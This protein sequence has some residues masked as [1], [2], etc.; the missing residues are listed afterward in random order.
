MNKL[1]PLGRKQPISKALRLHGTI[2]RDL[3]TAIMSGVYQPGDLLTGE[4]ASS[5]RLEV[6]RT[7][8]REAIR[9]LAAK[10]LVESKPKVGTKVSSRDKWHLLDPDVLAWAFENEPDLDLLNS[11]FELRNIV[12]S[13]AAALAAT[14]RSEMHLKKMQHAIRGMA[15]FTL[16]TEAG[17]QADQDFHTAL[18]QATENPFIA[19][20]TTG[21]NAAVNTTTVFKQRNRPL[22]R[23]PVP[24]HMRVF[25]AVAAKNAAGAQKAMSEL[26]Q[27]AR[28][29]TPTP[30]RSPARRA[31][32]R[33]DH[34]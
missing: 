23:D 9:I 7:A 27:L 28:L 13:A 10:G 31:R 17:R 8:Y 25:E 20:L 12:E 16:A 5:E 26:I 19:S 18:L 3:G 15:R 4:V 21:V 24:D 34:I 22:P 29:D 30:K 1:T 2:A 14:R 11:L 32:R 6:S 33:R